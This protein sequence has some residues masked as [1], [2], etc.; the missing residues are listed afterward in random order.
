MYISCRASCESAAALCVC[1]CDTIR[2]A[3]TAQNIYDI[4]TYICIYIYLTGRLARVLPLSP[5]LAH[6]ELGYNQISAHGASELALSLP[7]CAALSHLDLRHNNI[8]DTGAG[9]LAG[10]L[11]QCAAL[12]QLNLGHN[13]LGAQG[14]DV[15]MYVCMCICVCLCVC[16]CA[17]MLA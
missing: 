6:L 5:A 13:Q 10:V 16:V 9:S 17:C 4:Y 14:T 7:Q 12:S 2:S 1:M 3:L 11:P 15:C 8:G